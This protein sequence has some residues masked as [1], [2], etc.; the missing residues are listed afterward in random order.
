VH[1]D[2]TGPGPWGQPGW[3]GQVR[4][5]AH[6]QPDRLALRAGA[7]SR[8]YAEL[9]LEVDRLTSVLAGMG[10]SSGD[11]VVVLMG[12]SLE[13]VEVLIAVLRIGAIAVP[14]NFRLVPDEV[15]FLVTDSE[16]SAIV[17]DVER[18]EVVRAVRASCGRP[19]PCLVRRAAGTGHADRPGNAGS[20]GGVDAGTRS[21]EELAGPGA[22]WL[23]EALSAAA[24]PPVEAGFSVE[25]PAFIMYT[26]GT[27]GRPKGAVLTHFNLFCQSLHYMVAGQ[28]SEADGVVTAISVPGFHIAAIATL[29]PTMTLGGSCVVMPSGNFDP[30]HL[31]DTMEAEGVTD[32]FL[33]PTQWQAV[34]ALPGLAE[35]GLQLRSIGWGA[36]PATT[37]LLEAMARSFPGARV[38][39]LFG[40]TEMAPV[41]CALP[42]EDSLRKIGS[43]GKPVP[44]VD[45]RIVDDDMRDVPQGA[46]GEIVYRGPNLM[47]GYWRR[48][49]ATD[50]AFSGG[51]F[52]SGDLVRRDEEGFIY[53]VDRKKDM[54]LSGGENVYC[55]EV[56]QVLATHPGIDD[57]AVVGKPD[58][59][60]GETPVAFVVA[61][62]PA[63]PP[64]GTEVIEWCRGKMASYKRPTEVIVVPELPRNASGKVLKH[65]LR[66]SLA[67]STTTG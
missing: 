1:G 18:A 39:A 33:V 65:E 10:V 6:L 50:E 53:V 60:W 32:V 44:L 28:A 42:G 8:T 13:M 46:V 35:R 64:D 15:L 41:T 7:E 23:D 52:H 45:V 16:A 37:G 36:A 51:W 26:S 63:A 62:G 67:P 61:A 40:Q 12:N 9:D 25:A 4:R 2:A 54:I 31:V 14:V 49:E 30:A 59:R 22:R 29:V 38:V 27:T 34:C 58:P 48:P 47:A 66:A 55:A 57:V 56:E 43:V 5:H 21:A 20:P 24:G 17:T 19:I 11:R 3:A